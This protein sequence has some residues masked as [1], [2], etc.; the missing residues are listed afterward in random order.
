MMAMLVSDW[1]KA[2]VQKAEHMANVSIIFINSLAF[3]DGKGK[4]L[5]STTKILI[6]KNRFSLGQP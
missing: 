6:A 4:Q 2:I 1:L 5:T 3:L